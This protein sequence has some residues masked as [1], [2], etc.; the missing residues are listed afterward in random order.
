MDKRDYPGMSGK[1]IPEGGP[2][3][4]NGMFFG[5]LRRAGVAA[6]LLSGLVSAVAIAANT[7]RNF[8]KV[9]GGEEDYDSSSNNNNRNRNNNGNRR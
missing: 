5:F 6:F 9:Y 4:S 7:G 3:S 1:N 8:M 2:R